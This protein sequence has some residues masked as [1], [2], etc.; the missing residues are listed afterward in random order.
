MSD[1]PHLSLTQL[2]MLSKCGVAYENRYVK[3]RKVA[4]GVS[5]LVGRAVD[6]SVGFNLEHKMAG[7][8]L[9]PREA[10]A[11]FARD[12]FNLEW[13]RSNVSLLPEEAMLGPK[14][15]KGANADKSIRLAK[16]HHLRMAPAI[17]PTHLQ[18]RIAVELRNFPYDL[19]GVIDIQEGPRRLRDTKTSGK[20]PTADIADRD[21]QLTVYAMMVKV[22]DG[23]IPAKLS[24]DYL[25]DNAVPKAQAFETRRTEEDFR[26][27][28]HR[29]ERAALVLE[30][31]AFTPARETDWWCSPKWC[32][33]HATCPFVK[34]P[35]QF[36]V[37][38][39]PAAAEPA[40]VTL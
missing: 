22:T 2:D 39:V 30:K 1:K 4:P 35:K 28:L 16:L 5:L 36:A 7:M 19:E 25:I 14:R 8:G 21:D 24:L 27:L 11:D 29:I 37:P 10:V 20:T 18:R 31:G 17:E 12:A 34:Q 15:V 26:P 23:V 13:D 3:K 32:G 9:L 6:R 40:L 33:Y 38:A